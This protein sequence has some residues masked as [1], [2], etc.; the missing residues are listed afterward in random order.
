MP[1]RSDACTESADQCRMAR[2]GRLGRAAGERGRRLARDGDTP[3]VVLFA[4]VAGSTQAGILGAL[5]ALPTVAVL[6]T[7]IEEVIVP[8]RREH[9]R[10]QEAEASP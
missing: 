8:L 4:V 6:D 2:T 3:A 7:I 5:A 9:R 1:V 10:A